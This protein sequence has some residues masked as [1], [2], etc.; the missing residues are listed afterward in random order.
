MSR[1]LGTIRVD[2]IAGTAQFDTNVDKSRAKLGSFSAASALA[3]RGIGN[4]FAFAGRQLSG[5]LRVLTSAP[6]LIAGGLGVFGVAKLVSDLHQASESVDH[7]GKKA[8]VLGIASE[9]LSV[10]RFA[11]GEAGIDF[12]TLAN[13]AGKAQKSVAA[14]VR[15]GGGPAADALVRLGIPL[16][17]ANGQILTISELLPLI[18]TGLQ[19]VTS[20]ADKLDLATQI[21]GRA[22]GDQ[23]VQLLEDGG[24]F[25]QNMAVQAERAKR[26]GVVFDADQIKR[27]TEYNDAVGRIGEAW[28]G[29][30]VKIMTEAAP[31]LTDAAD[32]LASFFAAV[33]EVAENAMNRTR[34]ILTKTLSPENQA[35]LVSMWDSVG[36]IVAIGVKGVFKTLGAALID[37][38]QALGAF[39]LP[40]LKAVFTDLFVIPIGEAIAAG[41]EKLGRALV[42]F[43]DEIVDSDRQYMN[44]IG[45]AIAKQQRSIQDLNDTYD[46]FSAMMHDPAYIAK[47]SA[48]QKT[49]HLARLN[50]LSRTVPREKAKLAELQ[51][52]YDKYAEKVKGTFGMAPILRDAGAAMQG[53][54]ADT[55]A[56]GEE[57]RAFSAE[58]ARSDLNTA[59]DETFSRGSLA[60]ST[61]KGVLSDMYPHFKVILDSVDGL[62]GVSKAM[63]KTNVSAAEMAR[64]VPKAIA[65]PEPKVRS[66][67]QKFFDGLERGWKLARD[68]AAET[69]SLGREVFD[70]TTEGISGG[71]ASALAKG[72]ASWRNFGK[73][74][75]GVLGDVAQGVIETILKVQLMRAVLGVA[76]MLFPGQVATADTGGNA[77][78]SIGM[79]DSLGVTDTAVGMNAGGN[80][81]GRH[82]I[83]TSP[84]MFAAGDGSAQIMGERGA[85]GVLPLEEVGGGLGVRAVGMGGEVVVQIIDQRRAGERPQ[86]QQS[87]GARGETILRILVRD[88]VGKMAGDGSLDRIVGQ[89][90]GI[91]RRGT[92]R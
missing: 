24:D 50:A 39:G 35:L 64:V 2:L 29:V 20:Q 9:E 71:L 28:L 86:V 1:S 33:P 60:V 61:F 56:G 36:Q 32:R 81:F 80:A 38:A 70:Q 31:F 17:N 47:L 63:D 13:L 74:A 87:R 6:T 92:P 18:A 23:F 11:A 72:E 54:A 3:G 48:E 8:K 76:G 44:G 51:A 77:G 12:D 22:G 15:D 14:F 45:E 40:V 42:S 19:R 53:L 59:V 88:E 65:P 57:L 85:E 89:A 5:M 78:I 27:L 49:D 10:L 26:L 37:G 55:R 52:V 84:T 43:A 91:R 41:E 68:K 83:V 7:L 66:E 25:L 79:G 58:A 82:G 34:E 69:E 75:L 21:F 4:A 62:L 46:K 73:T 16:T 90:Y 30:K 67:W